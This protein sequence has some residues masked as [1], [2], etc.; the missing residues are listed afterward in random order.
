[1]ALTHFRMLI[2]EFLNK[3]KDIFPEEDP[4]IILDSESSACMAHNGKDTNHTRHIYRRVNLV[5]N[6]ENCKMHKTTDVKEV[7]NCHTL[8]LR[9]LEK[10]I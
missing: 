2:H 7:C 3:D 10:M 5:R 4:L 6:G 1:M 9:M 8:Q